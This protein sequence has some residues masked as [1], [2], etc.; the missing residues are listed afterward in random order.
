MI[1]VLR[2]ESGS[3]GDP[4]ERAEILNGNHLDICRFRSANDQ[5]YRSI[6]YNILRF[7]G[8][9]HTRVCPPICRLGHC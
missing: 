4:R 1:Q 8:E 5:S 9:E 7:V 2:R 3:F 6:S